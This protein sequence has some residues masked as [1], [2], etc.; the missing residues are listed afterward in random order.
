MSESSCLFEDVLYFPLLILVM[1]C[2]CF[3]FLQ[4]SGQLS[5]FCMTPWNELF[6]VVKNGNTAA[7]LVE[8]MIYS[9]SLSAA[10]MSAHSRGLSRIILNPDKHSS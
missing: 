7:F 3:G 8:Q 9:A 1:V 2:L 4:P 10:Q 6:K 5:T